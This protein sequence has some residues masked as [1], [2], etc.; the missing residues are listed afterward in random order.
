MG[1]RTTREQ[2]ALKIMIFTQNKK[3]ELKIIFVR[4]FV[5]SEEILPKQGKIIVNA[6]N[7]K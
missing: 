2:N 6:E 1:S 7:K 5:K 4:D 3:K